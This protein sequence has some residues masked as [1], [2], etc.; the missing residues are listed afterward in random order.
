MLS[1]GT[2][3]FW[4]T[5]ANDVNRL[6]GHPVSQLQG[7]LFYFCI[8]FQVDRY[9]VNTKGSS[10]GYPFGLH[11]S[12]ILRVCFHFKPM[13]SG[14]GQADPGVAGCKS[15][16]LLLLCSPLVLGIVGKVLN[17]RHLL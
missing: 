1:E 13:R 11:L 8:N 9:W 5:S 14:V 12:D 3:I 15:F 6:V 7:L 2:L 4:Y 10:S 17:V 16:P